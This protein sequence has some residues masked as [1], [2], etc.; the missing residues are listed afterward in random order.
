MKLAPLGRLIEN[1]I[2]LVKNALLN[3]ADDARAM[4]V[5]M[6]GDD[7]LYGWMDGC[8]GRCWVMMTQQIG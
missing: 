6:R 3:D 4:M 8:G 5:G 1:R 7:G 2:G